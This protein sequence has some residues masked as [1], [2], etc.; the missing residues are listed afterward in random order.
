MHLGNHSMFAPQ[1]TLEKYKPQPKGSGGLVQG[2]AQ[3]RLQGWHPAQLISS[4]QSGLSVGRL[5]YL[6][7]PSLW[8]TK[9]EFLKIYGTHFQL[10]AQTEQMFYMRDYL[11]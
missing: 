6:G 11:N 2:Q 1:Q 5:S 10:E 9:Q 7:P 8:H 4:G 3:R